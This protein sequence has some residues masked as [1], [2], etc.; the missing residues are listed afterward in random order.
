MTSYSEEGFL[1][2]QID[3]LEEAI[4]YLSN[5]ALQ[6]RKELSEVDENGIPMESVY[7]VIDLE[8]E[9]VK[10]LEKGKKNLT[11]KLKKAQ[12]RLEL[13]KNGQA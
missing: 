1:S 6:A 11:K 10:Q 2:D 3:M 9:V 5:L 8:S 13:I 12:N 4:A 7:L